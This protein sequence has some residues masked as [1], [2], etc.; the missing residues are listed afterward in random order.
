MG[1]DYYAI[2]GVSRDADAATLKKA[3]RK[4]AMKWHPDKNPD[5]VAE[6]QA[7]FQE[8]SEAYDV[9]SDPE[10]RQVYNEFGEEGLKAGAGGHGGTYTFTSGNAEE[11]FKKFFG[12]GNPFEDF[13]GMGGGRTGFTFTFGD[14][15]PR[16]PEPMVIPVQCTLE[17]LFKGGTRKL[18]VTRKVNGRDED[19]LIELE[20]KP[21][22]KDGTKIT[23]PGDGDQTPGLPPQDLVFVIKE[24]RHPRFARE[25]DD[26]C[27][28]K[29]IS[30]SQAL[31]GFTLREETIDGKTVSKEIDDIVAPGTERRIPGEGMPRKG[32]GR[33]DLVFRFKV[34]FPTSL[35][36]NQ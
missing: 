17:Q 5:N 12:G 6:A 34:K 2:L 28:E 9:L 14:E 10:K 15:R 31:T 11:I 29:T 19:K 13:F 18:K 23:Y 26:L 3:Y 36:R 8:I 16:A 33:G 21:G 1:R 7:K 35:T 30:L 22:W 24:Q 27:V 32:G 4:L 25:G 20:I